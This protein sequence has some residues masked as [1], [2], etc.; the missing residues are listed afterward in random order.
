[1]HALVTGSAG[2]IGHAL[3]RVPGSLQPDIVIGREAVEPRHAEARRQ[4]A[5]T[6]RVADEAGRARDDRRSYRLCSWH[7]GAAGVE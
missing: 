3:S 1:M 7:G 6:Q 5:A 4:Q 2:F